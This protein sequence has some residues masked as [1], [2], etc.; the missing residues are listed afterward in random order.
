MNLYD[1]EVLA[2]NL[3]NEAI[4]TYQHIDGWRFKWNN[5]KQAYGVCSYRTRTIQLSK[6]LTALQDYDDVKDTVLHELA[7]ALAG[8]RAGH[9]PVWKA[10]C[11]KLGANPQRCTEMPEE[12][13]KEAAR[14]AKYQI[15]YV[16]AGAEFYEVVRPAHRMAM[17]LYRRQLVGRPETLGRLFYV[18]TKRLDQP[19]WASHLIKGKMDDDF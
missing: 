1:A 15:V 13:K 4:N 19:D 9:G 16:P 6:F 14:L 7:H 8:G 5:R 12:Q 10:W 11:L 18:E 17:A 3:L 2:N